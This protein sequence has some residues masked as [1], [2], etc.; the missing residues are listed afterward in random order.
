MCTLIMKC[1]YFISKCCSSPIIGC[2]MYI[3]N[4]KLQIL[5]DN[6][7]TWNIDVFGNIHSLDKTSTEDLEN[8]KINSS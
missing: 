8:I 6:L 2:P 3:L 1:E 7:K 5:K 4:K